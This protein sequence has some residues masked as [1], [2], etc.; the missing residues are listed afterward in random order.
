MFGK[1]VFYVVGCLLQFV[2][3][4]IRFLAMQ[5]VAR[6]VDDVLASLYELLLFALKHAPPYYVGVFALGVGSKAMKGAAH[7]V[8]RQHAIF[9]LNVLNNGTPM[10]MIVELGAE[11]LKAEAECLSLLVGVVDELYLTPSYLILVVDETSQWLVRFFSASTTFSLFKSRF[12]IF[13]VF[14]YAKKVQGERN[15]AG[16]NC[17]AAAF[18]LQRYI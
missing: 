13:K 17:R 15:E 6:A 10:L 4:D 7:I 5:A 18:L 2:C 12:S 3:P 9:T 11:H 16:F 14:R 1:A 8:E